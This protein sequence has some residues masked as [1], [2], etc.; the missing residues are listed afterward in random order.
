MRVLCETQVF[1]ISHTIIKVIKNRYCLELK[2]CNSTTHNTAKTDIE[3]LQS[4]ENFNNNKFT[5]YGSAR[6]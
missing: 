6:L 1:F 4:F 5:K 2:Y 3:N